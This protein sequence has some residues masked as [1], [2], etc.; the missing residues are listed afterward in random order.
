MKSLFEPQ[1]FIEI[2]NRLN[3]LYEDSERKWGEMTVS[4]MMH[5]CQGP[6]NIILGKNDYGF[7]PN[8]LV[9]ML[10]KKAM[11]N[12][13]LWKKGLR[14]TKALKETQERHFFTEKE[15]LET[16][17]EEFQSHR[18]LQ[19][20]RPHPTFGKFT[21]EQWGKLQYKHLDH[22]LRQFGL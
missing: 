22:H 3:Q 15:N 10:F 2:K 4:Q 9:K 18:E 20:W 19:N 11:Y 16:L 21:K 6:L 7:K 12:D 14:T 8:W 13:T 1:A 17:L 5:H